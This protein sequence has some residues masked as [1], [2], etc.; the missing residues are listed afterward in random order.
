MVRERLVVGMAMSVKTKTKVVIVTT[1]VICG[2]FMRWLH[3]EPLVKW[4]HVGE[5]VVTYYI[6]NDVSV[7]RQ[8][9]AFNRHDSPWMIV[10]LNLR[11]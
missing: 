11:K 9:V 4:P 1:L 2:A 5:S 10:E 3:P 7:H 8:F 6:G